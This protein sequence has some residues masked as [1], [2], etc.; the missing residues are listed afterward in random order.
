V[1][2]VRAAWRDHGGYYNVTVESGHWWITSFSGT[3]SGAY[4][5]AA[6]T[7]IGRRTTDWLTERL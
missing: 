6:I 2:R 5:K 1:I 3:R 7:A 4:L